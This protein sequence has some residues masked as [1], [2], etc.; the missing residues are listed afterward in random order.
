MMM[1][2]HQRARIETDDEIV[3]VFVFVFASIGLV[4][5]VVV[6]VFPGGYDARRRRRSCGIVGRA[7]VEPMDDDDDDLKADADAPTRVDAY[8]DAHRNLCVRRRVVVFP[9]SARTRYPTLR[10]PLVVGARRRRPS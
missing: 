9:Q 10:L 3:R 2:M 6:L 7:V 8:D 5:V 1:M 4:V